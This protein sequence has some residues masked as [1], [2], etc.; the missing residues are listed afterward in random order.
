MDPSCSGSGTAISRMDH[1]LPSSASRQLGA[2]L[3]P[4][5]A[6]GQAP[7]SR[8]EPSEGV[9]GNRQAKRS[10][11]DRI[12]RLA[13]FQEAAVRHALTLPS[14]QRLVSCVST[15]AKVFSGC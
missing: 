6:A 7:S 14:L 12:E 9:G 2:G 10:E 8:L 3:D 5:A 13:R 1:L 11:C 4:S 15:T